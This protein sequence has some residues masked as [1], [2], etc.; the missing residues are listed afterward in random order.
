VRTLESWEKADIDKHL[1]KLV[2][3]GARLWW[4]KP[5]MAGYGKSGVS[6]YIG[7]YR[8]YF[9]SFEVKREGKEPT[10]IQDRRMKEME[11]AGGQTF[12]GTAAKIISEFD[13][14]L[15]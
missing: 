12:W 5:L 4:F 7:T 11:A 10:A 13:E 8:G 2:A 1:K 15:F 14:W 6:D 9:W 3:E